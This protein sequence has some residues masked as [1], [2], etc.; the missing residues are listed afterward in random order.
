[1]GCR[2]GRVYAFSS[3]V[4]RAVLRDQHSCQSTDS[5]K[6]LRVKV[7]SPLTIW[8][9]KST[10]TLRIGS[11]T[12]SAFTDRPLHCQGAPL[13]PT[14]AAHVCQFLG[15][16]PQGTKTRP[17]RGGRGLAFFL[18]SH[19]RLSHWPRSW[20]GLLASMATST[21]GLS[22]TSTAQEPSKNPLS[23]LFINSWCYR[24]CQGGLHFSPGWSDVSQAWPNWLLAW[25]VTRISREQ[26]A[27]Q[28]DV[29]GGE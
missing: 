18:P 26:T 12:G 27:L 15:F 13:P 6:Q 10:G 5:H 4:I 25:G 22:A 21:A 17:P 20:K 7:R 28:K 8:G 23:V 2:E 1:M 11:V 14:Q 9:A 24:G 3:D 16:L 29:G 19:Q